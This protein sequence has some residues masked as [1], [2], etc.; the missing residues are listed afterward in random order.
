MNNLEFKLTQKYADKFLPDIPI[1]PQGKYI[2]IILIRQSMSYAIFT[3]EGDILDTEK[4]QAGFNDG[5]PI[6]RVVMFKRKQIAP[7]RRTGKALIR[8]FVSS[9]NDCH[10]IDAMCG[11]CP[12]C[13]IYGYAAVEGV[14]ARKSRVITDSGFSVRPYQQIQ[15]NI[16]FNVIDEQTMTSQTITEFDHVKPQVFIPTVETCLDVTIPEVIYILGNILRTTRYGKESS[17]EGYLRNNL[18]CIAFSDTEL[19]S[20][21]ECSQAFYDAFANDANAKLADGY[22]SMADF[23]NHLSTVLQRLLSRIYGSITLIEG[24]ELEQFK[25][26]LQAFWSDERQIRSFLA[27]LN[28]AARNFAAKAPK[29]EE[30]PEEEG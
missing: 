2:S 23:T 14:G 7:E 5:Q 29:V 28:Q 13:L 19:F 11:K 20:N 4:V 21:L 27:S 25:K 3:T 24:E 30:E 6:D 8:Q 16:K 10:L 9:A 26:E 17:R 1:L 15:K 12:D 22:L 18:M